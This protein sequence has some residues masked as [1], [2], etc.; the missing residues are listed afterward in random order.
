MQNQPTRHHW[1]RTLAIYGECLAVVNGG[2][3]LLRPARQREKD[4]VIGGENR[5]RCAEGK[6]YWIWKS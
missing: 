4:S 5:L 6:G 2:P 3:G 1:Q